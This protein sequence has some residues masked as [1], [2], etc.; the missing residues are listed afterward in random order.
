MSANEKQPERKTDYPGFSVY[1]MDKTIDPMTDFYHY[2]AGTWLKS[3]PIPEDKTSWG[4]FTLLLER[5]QEILKGILEKC[6]KEP[7][8]PLRSFLGAFYGSA[9]NTERLEE[10]RLDPIQPLLD[11]VDRVNDAESLG[12]LIVRFHSLG[13]FPFFST[14]SSNDEKESSIYALYLWQ[15]GLTLP[16]RDYYL[17]DRFS[18]I[19]GHYRKHL[20][21]MSRL[22]GISAEGNVEETVYSMELEFARA[23]RS[24][25]ELRDAEKNYNRVTVKELEEKY[26]GLRLVA[27]L[28][29]MGVPE[30]DYVVV[31]QPEFFSFLSS[32]I[33]ERPLADLKT[34]LKWQ[35]VNMASPFLHEEV[36]MEHFDMF[37]RKIRGQKQP[38]PRWKR[39]VRVIDSSVGEALGKIY[40]EENFGPEARRRMA[41]MVDDIREVFVERLKKLPW[42][43][44]ATRELALAKFGRFRTK[45]G[46][47]DRFRD[48]SSIRISEEDYFGNVLRSSAFEVNRQMK[49]VG[50]QV[51]RNEWYMSPPTVNAYFN[52]TE[53]EI[54]FPAGILQPPFFDVAMDDA[55][56]YGAIGGVISHEITHGYDDQG[57]RYDQN[58]NLQNWWSE[59]DEKNFMERA[60]KVVKLY[61]SLEALPGLNVNGELT[62]GEN[63]AD[64]G[65]VSIAFEALQRRLQRHPDLRK[66]IDGLTPEQR[67]FISWAQCWKENVREEQIRMLV[68]VDPHSPSNFRGAVPVYNHP[69]FEKAFN[70]AGKEGHQKIDIW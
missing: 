22:T 59:E 10:L 14:Y 46:H 15:G 36:E 64:F 30:T 57:R 58:G 55:V 34:Y 68:T 5:N 66:N 2:A 37:N 21:T 6:R 29:G 4:S 17:S 7:S 20:E 19:R 69:D 32:F 3:N 24:R 62:L 33:S 70:A 13:I 1:H 65:G 27:Y 9:L 38:E 41:T 28:A 8:D 18:E 49:R 31:G 43:S 35:L 67:F 40:V 61:S 12:R 51:D 25:A 23:S 54:V 60:D 45:I 11:E 52:P 16:D 44:E 53:N 50:G 42:M 48:Y 56:N 47:P 26:P 63:I 39:A